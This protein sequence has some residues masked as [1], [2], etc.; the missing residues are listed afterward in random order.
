MCGVI[1]VSILKTLRQKEWFSEDRFLSWLE[2]DSGEPSCVIQAVSLCTKGAS[3]KEARSLSGLPVGV[4]ATVVRVV[5]KYIQIFEPGEKDVTC[6]I[7]A[8]DD[9]YPMLV[10]QGDGWSRGYW[11]DKDNGDLTRVCICH[12]HSSSECLCGAWDEE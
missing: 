5:K 9:R 12:A 8:E 4:S 2:S 7:T 10:L 3:Q 6:R 1:Q 11:V